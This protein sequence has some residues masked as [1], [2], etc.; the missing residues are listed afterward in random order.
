MKPDLCIHHAPCAD[1][2][3]AAWAIW[4]RWPDIEFHPGVYGAAPPDVTGKHVL[5]VDFSY[6]RPVL[7]EMARSA[8]SI[9]ILDHHKSAEEDLRPFRVRGFQSLEPL[10]VIPDLAEHQGILPIQALFDMDRSGAMLA[11]VYA[12]PGKD[13]P[14]LVW[15]VQ[16]RDL[17]RFEL[18]GTRAIQATV[19]S[20][21]YDFAVWDELAA[22][23]ETEAGRSL[24][25]AQGEAI[26][27]KH[28][29]DVAELLGLCTREMVIGGHRVPVANLPYTLSSDGAGQLAEGQPFGACYYDNAEGRRVFSLRSRDGGLDV[30]AIAAHYGG[31]GHARAAGFT[32]APGWEGGA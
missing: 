20:Y 28:Q 4:K 10:T 26:E 23:L 7:E 16:D 9:T 31:G 11:W 14:R 22:A 18:E 32:A 17:W 3:T 2:F 5:I 29:K 15:H 21:P 1:G 8:K 19:F 25:I 30:S 6:K 27:R 13:A 12:H 24:I